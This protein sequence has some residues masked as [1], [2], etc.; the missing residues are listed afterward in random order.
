MTLL[1]D[2]SHPML[3]YIMFPHPLCHQDMRTILNTFIIMTFLT[4]ILLYNCCVICYFSAWIWDSS[5][6]VQRLMRDVSLLTGLDTSVSYQQS[7]SEPLQVI[8]QCIYNT[9]I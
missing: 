7:S 2:V 3:E 8:I 1:L 4:Y 6:Q 9:I 5:P